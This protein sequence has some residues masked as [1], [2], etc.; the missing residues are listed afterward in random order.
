MPTPGITLTMTELASAGPPGYQVITVSMDV[1]SINGYKGDVVLGVTANAEPDYPSAISDQ[2]F[3]FHL[4]EG[5]TKTRTTNVTIVGTCRV[6]ASANG[7][8]AYAEDDL[9]ITGT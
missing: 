6:L 5:Q 7:D 9:L 8:S 3:E 1:T 4:N 2:S